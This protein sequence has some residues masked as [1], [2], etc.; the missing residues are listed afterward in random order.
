MEIC[1]LYWTPSVH[2]P[3]C[4]S[5]STAGPGLTF[6][7]PIESAVAV[8]SRTVGPTAQTNLPGFARDMKNV[9]SMSPSPT[10]SPVTAL[11]RGTYVSGAV[12]RVESFQFLPMAE[13]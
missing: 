12:T 7:V 11:A 4:I 5:K 8:G 3:G 1:S 13:G 2:L 10:V 9:V 6:R